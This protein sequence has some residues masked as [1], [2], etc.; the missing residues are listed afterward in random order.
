VGYYAAFLDL[1][2]RQCLVVGG[3]AEAADKARG[4]LAA[5]AHVVVAWDEVGDEL[6]AMAAAGDVALRR[7]RFSAHD[8]DSCFLVVDASLDEATG[9]EVFAAAR[10]R[11]VLCNVLD[12]PARCDFI[13]P[14]LLRRGPLQVAISTSGRSPFMASHLRKQLES[15]VDEAQGQLVELVGRL[16]DRMRAAGVSLDV[17]SDVYA[18][19][20]ASG[21]LELLRQGREGDAEEAVEACAKDVLAPDGEASGGRA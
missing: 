12:R 1:S 18:R 16:R 5:G 10:R 17:Q 8:L 19:V 13:A 3:G 20:P 9:I 7:H 6:T 11:L 14:A 21:A 4:L 2:D 15:S